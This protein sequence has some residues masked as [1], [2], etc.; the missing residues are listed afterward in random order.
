MNTDVGLRLGSANQVFKCTLCEYLPMSRRFY[1]NLSSQK[2]VRMFPELSNR[3][4][5]C[6]TILGDNYSIAVKVIVESERQ[7]N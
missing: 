1:K 2:R 4:A 3:K 5:V 6:L 7:S